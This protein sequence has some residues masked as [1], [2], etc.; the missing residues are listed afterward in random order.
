M[1]IKSLHIRGD[2]DLI[3]S[4]INGNFVAKKPTLKQYIDDVWDAMKKI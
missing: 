4:Q 1:N 2:S 3:V